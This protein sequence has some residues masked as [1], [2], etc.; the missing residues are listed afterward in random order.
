MAGIKDFKLNNETY[1]YFM[2]M[3]HNL[4]RDE[5]WLVNIRPFSGKRSLDA[6]AQTW[7][8]YKQISSQTG[9]DIE[10]VHRRCKRDFGLPILFESGEEA[11]IVL[12]WLLNKKG[13]YNLS[14]EQQLKVMGCF[15]VTSLMTT[16]QCNEYRDNMQNFFN[17]NGFDL[18]YVGE[19]PMGE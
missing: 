9:D 15:S 14:E 6:N 1:G 10:T 3:L 18:R 13:F 7:V 17:N 2:T 16:K 19:P 11:G 4:P 5:Q 8:W 12:G